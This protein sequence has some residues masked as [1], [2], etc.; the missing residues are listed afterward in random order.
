MKVIESGAIAAV[1]VCALAL[2]LQLGWVGA[3]LPGRDAGMSAAQRQALTEIGAQQQQLE[4]NM[5]EI[6][7]ALER[8]K[9]EL[10]QARIYSKRGGGGASQ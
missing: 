7:A 9:S 1:L 10:D 3:Q 8:I 6:E 4:A 2:M 5:A